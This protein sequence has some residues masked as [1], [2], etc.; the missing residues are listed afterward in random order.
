MAVS[1]IFRLQELTFHGLSR[2]PIQRW[3][4]LLVLLFFV[5]NFPGSKVYGQTL[6]DA[7]D[8]T[9]LVWN[10]GGNAPWMGQTNISYDGEAAAQSGNITNNQESWLETMLM[11]PGT[12]TFRWKVS[13]EA[14]HDYLEFYSNGMLS[15]R[16][17]GEVGWQYKSYPLMIGTQILRWRYMKDVLTAVGSDR[18]WLDTVTWI[19][20]NGPPLIITQ[21]QGQTNWSGTTMALTVVAG[22]GPPLNYQWLFRNGK[23]TNATNATLT[24]SNVASSQSGN[25]TVV[26]S[27]SMA[28]VTSSVAK[29][30]ILDSPP[31]I[32]VFPSNKAAYVS[33]TATFNVVADGSRPLFYQWFLG[34]TPILGAT[35][36]SLL[37][38]NVQ[39]NQA[40]IYY[41]MVSNAFGSVE[42]TNVTL[43][44]FQIAAW[45]DNSAK[46]T[47]VPARLTNVVAIAAG[48]YHSL[49][50]RADGT[51]TAWGNNASGQTNIPVG[52][53]TVAAIAAGG[54]HNL[55]LKDDGAVVTWGDNSWGQTTIPTGLSNVVAIAGGGYHSLA[56]KA[57]GTVSAWGDA[58]S[59]QTK[60]PVDLSNVVAIAGGGNH[61]LALTSGGTVI[62]WGDNGWGQINVPVG[63]SNVVAIAGGWYHSLALKANGTVVAWGENS[64]GQTSFPPLLTNVMAIA[65][66]GFHSL[67]L[68]TDGTVAVVGD[69]SY[70]Q[71]YPP[72]AIANMVAIA[73]GGFHSLE[74][75]DTVPK[76]PFSVPLIISPSYGS[77]EVG[78]PFYFRVVARNNAFGYGATGLP[79]GLSLNPTNGLINGTPQEAGNFDVA[80]Y[81]TN[82]FGVGQD[83]LKLRINGPP[84][85]KTTLPHQM[86]L[87]GANVNFTI[88]SSG[89][90][91]LSFQWR[92]NGINI[93]GATNAF[94][95]L[96]NVQPSNGGEYSVV[97]ANRYGSVVSTPA[98]LLVFISS[99]GQPED[100]FYNRQPLLGASGI[101]TATNTL[102]T[103]EPG[104]PFHADKPG[105]NS[106]WYTWEAPANGI[107]TLDTEGSTFDTLLAVYQGTLLTNL[108]KVAADDD[109]GGYFASRVRFNALAGQLYQIAV[110]GYAGDK[111]TFTLRWDLEMT[112]EVL[113]M[114]TNEPVSQAAAFGNNVTFQV[115]A[116]GAGLQYQWTFNGA[117]IAG[118]T[119]A[120]LT[121]TNVQ[122]GNVG[123]YQARVTNPM[124]RE[125]TSL[126]AALEIGP[127]DG[128]I[129]VDKF[130]DML[131]YAGPLPAP[132]S[133]S[134]P[135][136][137][138]GFGS[139]G[140]F[141]VAS[142]TIV[143]QLFS[144]TNSSTQSREPVPCRNIGGASRWYTLK[145]Q[146]N[147]ILV[148]DTTGSDFDTVMMVFSGD[149]ANVFV[150]G[151]LACDDDGAADGQHSRIQVAATDGTTFYVSVDGKGGASGTAQLNCGLGTVPALNVVYT[152]CSVLEGDRLT[153]SVSP[154]GTPAP[155]VQWYKDGLL[156]HDATNATLTVD[157]IQISDMGEYG[158]VVSN[159]VSSIWVPVGQVGAQGN[160]YTVISNSFA[161]NQEGWNLAG[162]ALA[163]LV[164]TNTG[165][166]P[167][168]C[169]A[170]VQTNAMYIQSPWAMQ[171]PTNYYGNQ[172][173]AYGGL[174][175]FELLQT[176]NQSGRVA[177]RVTMEG[178]GLKLVREVPW[179][180]GTGWVT[181]RLVLHELAGWQKGYQGPYANHTEML[182]ALGSLSGITIDGM[183]TSQAGTVN[184]D[185]IRLLAATARQIAQLQVAN[186]I[187]VTNRQMQIQWADVPV[188]FV[189]EGND[190]LNNQ[191]GWQTVPALYDTNTGINTVNV[192]MTNQ[193]KF[194][195]LKKP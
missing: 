73:G 160:T 37:F 4:C 130:Q 99:Q 40:G 107:A 17:S 87:I 105:S 179:Q 95:T 114:I 110:D 193:N 103:R 134:G 115:G 173:A 70:G 7:L 120:T 150:S 123:W 66:G 119:N 184:L 131:E 182:Q 14:N 15:N 96:P 3:G 118:A 101:A 195:R 29:L 100:F 147:G 92:K 163:S 26:V 50:L 132:P 159:F 149:P 168:G 113:P 85:I 35:N 178:G 53:T 174:L 64:H 93:P 49:A 165:G 164:Y 39:F 108:I 2:H 135:P 109:R 45:G 34:R 79:L 112:P 62:A 194:L 89:L 42:C 44:V 84:E 9:N 137:Q 55:A 180:T 5:F 20:S 177:A 155:G 157:K 138:H 21:P 172:V 80:L 192:M 69:N 148:L 152:N 169:L 60:V 128:V 188:G 36:A 121:V 43:S 154:T 27:N 88:S 68:K 125:V 151:P 156:L 142:G 52:L 65:A 56:L 183:L 41:V 185:N 97:V 167:D 83:T 153:L 86:V 90:T 78:V 124:G 59:G 98:S 23:I 38:T 63:L 129:S 143:Q 1:I 67:A 116:V 25:Y 170:F 187:T 54:L 24:L 33:S 91:P 8:Q 144:T 190:A 74:L 13:S 161:G 122:R 76:T 139:R 19:P 31:I 71:I 61:S 158:V 140:M 145:V 162:N 181:Y 111:G 171:A 106:V 117:T 6:T 32:S 133:Q 48:G 10:T 191:N 47:N 141:S 12:L 16:I 57:D 51:V 18:G 72:P 189:L 75:I 126:P 22:G 81:A 77:G 146:G 104:E 46:Q 30:S 58:T 11:G 82:V 28:T 176:T 102:A 186:T 166:N 127:V 136:P 94:L 175:V